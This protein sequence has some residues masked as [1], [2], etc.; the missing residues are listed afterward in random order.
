MKI[1]GREI[2]A[3]RPPYIVADIGAAH[4]GDLTRALRLIELAHWAGADAVKFQAFTPEGDTIDCDRPEFIIQSGPWQGRR[5]YDLY[6]ET[7]T[8]R[9][10]FPKLFKHAKYLGITAFATA[11]TIDDWNFLHSIGNPVTKISSFEIAH[12]PLIQHA[13]SHGGPMILSLGTAST[14]ELVDAYHACDTEPVLLHC[15]SE[16]PAPIDKMN[17]RRIANL[18]CG[19]PFVGLSDH[20]LGSVAPVMATALGACMIEKHLTV[21][22]ADGGPDDV[23]AS[24]PHEFKLMVKEVRS[25]HA[26]LG[27]GLPKSNND[28]R[29][30][31]PSIR[32]VKDISTGEQFTLENVRI[33]RPGGGLPP[34]EWNRL[35]ACRSAGPI[36]RGEAIQRE[37]VQ[38]S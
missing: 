36:E 32:A 37:M 31:R 22:R 30:L 11:D 33:I 15:V 29:T 3:G 19:F 28:A 24:E 14:E 9:G 38:S 17:L 2:G 10:W 12:I 1:E 25:A 26:A 21:S 8:P 5:L 13:S 16:Y 18:G 4:N 23:F 35:L 27:D 34:I 7:H 6:I 20:S